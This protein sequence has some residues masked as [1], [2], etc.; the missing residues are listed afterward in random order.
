MSIPLLAAAAYQRALCLRDL[1]DATA[2]PHA[3]QLLVSAAVGALQN[4]WGCP[5]IVYRQPPVVAI[6]DNYDRLHVPPEAVARDARY[7]RYVTPGLVLRTHTTAAI[8]G[9]LRAIARAPY[10][11]V[12]LACPG[13]VYRRDALDRLHAAEPHQLD[14]WR[15][16]AGTLGGEELRAM[17]TRVVD[18]VLPG[19]EPRATPAVHPYTRDGL[20]LDVRAAD[21]W[22]EIGEC[23]LALP[24]VL[25]ECGLPTG[26][27]GLAMGLGLDRALMLRKGIDD[28]RLLRSAD[29]R[30]AAQMRD[31]AP[32]RPVSA[33]PPIRR[34]LS[35]AVASDA[36]PEEL[37]DRVRETL[38]PRAECVEAMEVRS[39]TAA[40]ALPP[41]AAARLGIGPHQKNVLLR[42][43]L[44]HPTR[45]LTAEEA[46]GLRDEVYA[47]LHAGGVH[48]WAGGAR[49]STPP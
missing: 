36:T 23:G 44:R 33:Q 11:D 18:A 21:C 9:L 14:L 34:D 6:D 31:L 49:R 3:M 24:A 2:G 46:N 20:Q 35:L 39:E 4:A 32:Y 10:A 38:G 45:T 37:G 1:T 28:I 5:V 48:H 22:V 30:V 40:A 41:A 13:L 25:E 26:Y 29:P 12:L 17:I 19:A 15:I 27:A 42:L 7:T 43:V 8:P 47:A 16:R